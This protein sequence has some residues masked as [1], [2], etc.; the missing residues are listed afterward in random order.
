[1]R[2]RVRVRTAMNPALVFSQTL[3]VGFITNTRRLSSRRCAHPHES[4]VSFR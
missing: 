2:V 3:L 4:F 1:M